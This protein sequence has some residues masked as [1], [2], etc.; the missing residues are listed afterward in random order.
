MN[1][2]IELALGVGGAIIGICAWLFRLEGR[3]N[4]HDTKHDQHALCRLEMREDLRYIRER[5]DFAL[6]NKSRNVD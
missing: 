1:L 6:D 3:V 4:T 5:I 2:S